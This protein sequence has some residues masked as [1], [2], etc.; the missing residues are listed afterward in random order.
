[1]FTLIYN[2]TTSITSGSR[3]NHKS[4]A[5]H[6]H[7]KLTEILSG[8]VRRPKK[9]HGRWLLSSCSCRLGGDTGA[10]SEY[11]IIQSILIRVT[12]NK[13]ITSAD[14]LPGVLIKPCWV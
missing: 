14:I 3:E 13:E 1:M 4:S 11:Y 12:K 7:L 9:C 6:T 2:V 5:V 8:H 10:S